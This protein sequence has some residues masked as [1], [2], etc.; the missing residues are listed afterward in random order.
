MINYDNIIRNSVKIGFREIILLLRTRFIHVKSRTHQNCD[1]IFP[2]MFGPNVY[3]LAFLRI[4]SY[5]PEISC[6]F[7]I[8][9][10]FE[11]L[12]GHPGEGIVK[13]ADKF[14]ARYIICGS[15]GHGGL[16][17]TILG[18]VSGYEPRHVI[19]NNVV[20]SDDPVQPPL[21]L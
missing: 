20:Y 10:R 18:T 5:V 14:N 19:S 17:R 4:Y 15:R 12:E 7:Q 16:R 21:K 13:A 11:R 8:K 6:K 1:R 2:N 3:T 9:H